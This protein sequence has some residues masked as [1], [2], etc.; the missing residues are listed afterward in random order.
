MTALR[1]ND[2]LFDVFFFP[3]RVVS[4]IGRGRGVDPL[5]G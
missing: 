1:R 2:D 5:K 3:V 4:A